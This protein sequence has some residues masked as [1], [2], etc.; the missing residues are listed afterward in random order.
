MQKV[1]H[2]FKSQEGNKHA[3]KNWLKVSK[4]TA[5]NRRT[6]YQTDKNLQHTCK[7]AQKYLKTTTNTRPKQT[8]DGQ[9]DVQTLNK[10]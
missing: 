9:T 8:T 5:D 10:N 2:E 1:K 4:V 6:K 3:D 7:N